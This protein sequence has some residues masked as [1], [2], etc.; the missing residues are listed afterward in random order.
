MREANEDILEAARKNVR[1]ENI[2]GFQV[3]AGHPAGGPVPPRVYLFY[4]N[5]S[6]GVY[7]TFEYG[8]WQEAYTFGPLHSEETAPEEKCANVLMTACES[9]SDD[10][11]IEL[12]TAGSDEIVE[13]VLE[14]VDLPDRLAITREATDY[15]P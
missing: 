1:D 2:A 3:G 4:T 7:S 15:I 12:Y 10:A 14:H 6:A 13:S 5:E 9:V 8:D 11:N